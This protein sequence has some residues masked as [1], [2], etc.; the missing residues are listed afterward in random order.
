[1]DPR[2]EELSE[3]WN[4]H[5]LEGADQPFCTIVVTGINRKKQSSL[6]HRDREDSSSAP[7]DENDEDDDEEEVLRRVIG[8]QIEGKEPPLRQSSHLFLIATDIKSPSVFSLKRRTWWNGFLKIKLAEKPDV[9]F[10]LGGAKG[11]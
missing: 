4:S 11:S 7:E 5:R 6:R 9:I 2:Q 3:G 8:I 1:M 10:G